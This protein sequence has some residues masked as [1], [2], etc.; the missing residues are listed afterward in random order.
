MSP[1][2]PYQVPSACTHLPLYL[3]EL[4]SAAKPRLAAGLPGMTPSIRIPLWPPRPND[5]ASFVL[6]TCGVRAAIVVDAERDGQRVL[7]MRRAWRRS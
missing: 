2:T 1:P 7:C 5:L 6:V 4:S 3:Q